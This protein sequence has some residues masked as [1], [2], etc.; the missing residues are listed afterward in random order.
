MKFRSKP[1]RFY[2]LGGVVV[3]LIVSLFSFCKA[4][5]SP[6]N[7]FE[8][9]PQYKWYP[10]ALPPAID[11]AGERVPLDRWDVRE[12]LDRELITNVYQHG[13]ILLILKQSTRYFPAIEPILKAN[14]IPDDFKFLCVAESSL[15]P[16]AQSVVAAASLWQFMKDTAPRYGLQ[17]DNEVDERYNFRKSTEAACK[18]FK[19]AYSKLGTWTAVAASYNCGLAGYAK[20]AE[21]QKATNYYDLA[22][23]EETNRYVYRILALK[24]ILN[25]PSFFGFMVSAS[26]GYKPIK[27]KVIV[28]DKSI[29]NLAEFA[30]A[31]GSNYK[32]LKL[33]NPWLR[34]HTLTV[35]NGKTYEIELPVANQ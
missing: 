29:D 7:G 32:M 15:Q 31:N 4:G 19:E 8:P 22:F 2:F 12:R 24:Y 11:F 18:Y 23:P 3:I 20:Q 28:V 17:V 10:P 33:L 35:K 30:S 16:Q 9:K 21:F 27:T 1:Y 26:D 13:S 14:G 5:N 25:H 34:A 6:E